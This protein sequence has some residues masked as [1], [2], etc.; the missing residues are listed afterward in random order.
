MI[1]GPA[2][3]C[4]R[5]L[6]WSSS[7]SVSGIGTRASESRVGPGWLRDVFQRMVYALGFRGFEFKEVG[8]KFRGVGPLQPGVV[9]TLDPKP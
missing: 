5:V 6:T 3:V 4:G 2:F 8:A 7:T 1:I 9:E